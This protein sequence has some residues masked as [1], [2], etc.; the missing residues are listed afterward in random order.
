MTPYI[1]W[2]C[3]FV[4]KETRAGLLNQKKKM[5]RISAAQTIRFLFRILCNYFRGNRGDPKIFHKLPLQCKPF[6]PQEQRQHY[7]HG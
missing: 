6:L 3:Y 7:V 5:L 1:T 4:L 2:A